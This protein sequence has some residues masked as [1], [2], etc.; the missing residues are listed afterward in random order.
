MGHCFGQQSHTNHRVVHHQTIEDKLCLGRTNSVVCPVKAL[1]PYL[2]IRV[3]SQGCLFTSEDQTPLTR[4]QFK[5]LLS[6]MLRLAGLD[7]SNYNT[8]SFQIGAATTAKAISIADVHIQL[9]GWWRSSA[10]QGY[11]KMPTPVLQSS[12]CP[13][14]QQGITPLHHDILIICRRSSQHRVNPVHNLCCDEQTD[15]Y[16]ACATLLPLYTMYNLLQ[17]RCKGLVVWFM[18]VVG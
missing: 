5:T 14:P 13:G 3:S 9:L 4:A 16:R 8:Q 6:S 10:Y 11:I 1:L 12:W 17:A 15:S 7:D 18:V 2:A